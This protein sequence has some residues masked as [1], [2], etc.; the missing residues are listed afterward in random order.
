METRT[1][2]RTNASIHL[3]QRPAAE[4]RW[5]VL[6]HGSG[7]DGHMFDDQIPAVP[8][9]IG[10]CVWDARGHGRSSLQGPFNYE[11]LVD[12]LR[13]LIEGLDAHEVTLVG[14]SMGGNLAQ[15]YVERYPQDVDR[16]VL[17]GCTGNH[18]PLSRLE[19][20]AMASAGPILAM[21]PWRWTVAQSARVCGT[22]QSTAEYARRSLESIGKRRFI[23]V[24][25]SL[26]EALRPEPGYRLPVPALLLCGSEDV[27]GNIRAAMPRLAERNPDAELVIIDG[28][29]HNANMDRPEATN[30]HLVA[31]LEE[32]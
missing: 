3:R 9:D 22:K 13:A 24:L 10:I 4:G 28:A 26:T 32:N 12:D 23:E 8:E 5:V 20:L 11:D 25:G 29:A 27:S 7:M 17:I 1:L 31:F 21:T 6:L 15:T 2:D 16:I 30:Q 19:R 18:G 14:Q